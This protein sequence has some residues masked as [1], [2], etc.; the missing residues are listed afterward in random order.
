MIIGVC[1]PVSL[2]FPPRERPVEAEL[3]D[4]APPQKSLRPTETSGGPAAGGGGVPL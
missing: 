3:R 2:L 1:D 4:A